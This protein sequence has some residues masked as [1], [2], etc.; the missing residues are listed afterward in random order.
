MALGN[1]D[2]LA[3][4]TENTAPAHTDPRIRDSKSS[5][6]SRPAVSTTAASGRVIISCSSDRGLLLAKQHLR[7]QQDDEWCRPPFITYI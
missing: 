3:C 2:I 4:K 5:N 6:D 1:N 7:E